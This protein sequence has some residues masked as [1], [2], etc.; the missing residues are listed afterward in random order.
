MRIRTTPQYSKTE[1]ELHGEPADFS[2]D[3]EQ[4]PDRQMAIHMRL[5][6][7]SSST[8]SLNCL[9]PYRPSGGLIPPSALAPSTA[10]DEL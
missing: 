8:H 10:L 1:V 9:L 2:S 6:K 4:L 3:I 7:K 5:P